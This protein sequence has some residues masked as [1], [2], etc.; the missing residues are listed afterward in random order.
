MSAAVRFRRMLLALPPA[1]AS[2]AWLRSAT[3]FAGVLGLELHAL[4]VEDEEAYLAA[5]HAPA[6]YAPGR[7][8]PRGLDPARL[9]ADF[10]AL[11]R[12]MEQ[13]LRLAAG[14]S[15]AA[16]AVER[17]RGRLGPALEARRAAGDILALAGP[18]APGAVL[19]GPAIGSLAEELR[20][21]AALTLPARLPA[22]PG[23]VVAALPEG[24][25]AGAALDLAVRLALGTG[26]GLE[27]WS[28]GT[29][30]PAPFAAE[31]VR[32]RARDL[33]ALGDDAV[34]SHLLMRRTS[35]LVLGPARGA[36]AERFRRLAALGGTPVLSVSEEG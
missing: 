1:G 17:V 28:A 8:G 35:C 7:A 9:E 23:L 14:G 27:V 10:R 6:E 4:L 25:A 2:D 24:A 18:E 29:A 22:R 19:G 11:A 33:A 3:G 32:V 5:A 34:V 31:G 20:F 30:V 21:G 15:G 12:R 13:R 16:V 36:A 26:G